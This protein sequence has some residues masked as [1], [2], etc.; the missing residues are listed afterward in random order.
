MN[1]LLGAAQIR[2]RGLQNYTIL[3]TCAPATAAT[4]SCTIFSNFTWGNL[5]NKTKNVWRR[6][7]QVVTGKSLTYSCCTICGLQ[8]IFADLRGNQRKKSYKAF[9]KNLLSNRKIWG[10][11][12]QFSSMTKIFFEHFF[13]FKMLR[14][15]LIRP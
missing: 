9:S 6:K 4:K 1:I 8:H 2:T 5:D 7:A 14:Y 15:V 12:F 13:L 10:S 11:D 3:Q